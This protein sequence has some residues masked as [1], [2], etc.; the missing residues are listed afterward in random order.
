VE[1]FYYKY[2]SDRNYYMAITTSTGQPAVGEYMVFT[3][4]ANFF[5]EE[6]NYLVSADA[7]CA[8]VCFTSTDALFDMTF[9]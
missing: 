8:C 6:V 1:L 9:I 5:I 2:W 4:R 7:L 3:L